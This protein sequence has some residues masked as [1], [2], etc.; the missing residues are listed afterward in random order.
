MDNYDCTTLS[1]RVD[2]M[3]VTLAQLADLVQVLSGLARGHDERITEFEKRLFQLNG[4]QR[5]E[6]AESR[7]H[8][9]LYTVANLQR[10]AQQTHGPEAGL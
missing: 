1:E 5:F 2:E 8:Q 4:E 10:L 7:I 3:R 9:L 6:V